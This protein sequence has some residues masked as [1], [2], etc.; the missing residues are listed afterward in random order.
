MNLKENKGS[1]NT[2]DNKQYLGF[3]FILVKQPL[4]IYIFMTVAYILLFIYFADIYLCED[5]N[6]EELKGKLT[7]YII[8]YNKLNS[9]FIHYDHLLKKAINHP[10]RH[11]D[12]E[13]YLCG[14]KI[15]KF[16]E[17][18]DRYSIIRNIETNIKKI[19]PNFVS[20]ILKDL[21]EL[22]DGY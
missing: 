22:F 4:I 17:M 2:I 8:E 16:F 10:E 7:T 21:N 1:I 13:E 15:D 11:K 20:T 12:I 6:L 18:G 9:E 14:K 5:N 19:E 3:I